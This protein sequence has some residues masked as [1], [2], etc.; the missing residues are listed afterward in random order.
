MVEGATQVLRYDEKLN[1][2]ISEEAESFF[3][4]QKTLD[5][6]ADIIQNRASTYISESR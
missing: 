5:V 6:V 1:A 4:G 3:S 2:I